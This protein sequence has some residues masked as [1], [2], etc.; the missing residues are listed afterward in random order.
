MSDDENPYPL[1][2]RGPVAG[3]IR[4]RYEYTNGNILIVNENSREHQFK[5][6][7]TEEILVSIYKQFGKDWFPLANNVEKLGNDMEIPGLGMTI[8]NS[9]P[10]NITKAQAASYFGPVMEDMGIFEWNQKHMGIAW[11]LIREPDIKF[12]K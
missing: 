1:T 2:T 5:S 9:Y 12:L 6:H 7:K 3:A 10:G 4:F 11:R 8:L